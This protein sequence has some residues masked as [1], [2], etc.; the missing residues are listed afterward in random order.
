MI[1]D[2]IEVKLVFNSKG[3]TGY[4]GFV[5]QDNGK[6]LVSY[7]SVDIDDN[8]ETLCKTNNRKTSIYITEVDLA[9]I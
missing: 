6:L 3:D 1:G 8:E 9:N 2:K 4:P 5:L 7:Y